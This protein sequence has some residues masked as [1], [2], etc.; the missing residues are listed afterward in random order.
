MIAL[1][2]IYKK[3]EVE[4]FVVLS[5]LQPQQIKQLFSIYE[6]TILGSG[7]NK[8]FFTSIWSKNELHRRKVDTAIKQVLLPSISHY[9][10]NI[11]P[12]FANFMVKASGEE[13]GLL[14][15]QDWSFVDEPAFES[16]TVWVPLVDVNQQN[17]NMQVVPGSH[18][19]Y[20]NYIR[21]RFADAPFDRDAEAKNLID[22]PMKAGD[23]LLFNSRLIHASPPNFSG[24][25]RVAASVVITPKEATLKHWLIKDSSVEE[26]VVDETFYW[27]YSCY[28]KLDAAIV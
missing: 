10:P 14:P 21:A 20:R 26:L 6:N 25:I 8:E 22:L 16:Y 2:N 28:D 27:K 18:A 3:L 15:H 24:K 23:A 7:V 9:F 19:K 11:Q 4:G 12:A 13:S 1:E 5:L 17:G